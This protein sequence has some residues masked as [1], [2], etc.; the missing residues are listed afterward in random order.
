MLEILS[1][2]LKL[3]KEKAKKIYNDRIK[4]NTI[5]SRVTSLTFTFIL[6]MFT[7]WTEQ[8]GIFK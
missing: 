7:I 5:I 6:A 2:K 1:N 8:V 3:D 4:T